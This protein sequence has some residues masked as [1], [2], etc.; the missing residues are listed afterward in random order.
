MLNDLDFKASL[1]SFCKFSIAEILIHSSGLILICTIDGQISNPSIV[2][3]TQNSANLICKS[4]A[5]STKNSS[6]I[7]VSFPRF[8]SN[9][10]YWKVGLSPEYWMTG[11]GFFS[12]IFCSTLALNIS[13]NKDPDAPD[14]V[15]VFSTIFPV[16][17]ET[18]SII[19]SV[20]ISG[21]EIVIVGLAFSF[22][23]GFSSFFAGF[24]DCSIVIL[25][26]FG[27]RTLST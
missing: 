20:E 6:S 21:R 1:I 5:F 15:F 18:F 12:S 10:E 25:G 24:S 9:A 11:F 2:I 19:E 22:E 26:N 14:P 7:L 13:L 17:W 23:S 8:D 16:A 27:R 4:F 3:G